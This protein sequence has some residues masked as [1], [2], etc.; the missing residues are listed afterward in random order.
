VV[1]LRPRRG[2]VA[3]GASAP[4]CYSR[5]GFSQL[6]ALGQPQPARRKWTPRRVS[7]DLEQ[8]LLRLG[9]RWRSSEES[10]VIG[11]SAGDWDPRHAYTAT[12]RLG[13]RTRITGGAGWRWRSTDA[14]RSRGPEA[15]D[16]GPASRRCW[17]GGGMDVG[18][19]TYECRQQELKSDSAHPATTQARG[20]QWT[21]SLGPGETSTPRDRMSR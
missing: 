16:V 2:A 9:A 4:A 12:S 14:S 21:E 17:H 7:A 11:A 19:T 13:I 20:D 5:A 10:R 18:S 6:L 15:K 8:V 3:R 1:A